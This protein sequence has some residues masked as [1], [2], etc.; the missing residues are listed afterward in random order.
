MTFAHNTF[1]GGILQLLSVCQ[2]GYLCQK[3]RENVLVKIEQLADTSPDKVPT[4][5]RFLLE[6]DF[7]ILVQADLNTQQYWVVAV[8]AA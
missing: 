8:C 1:A 5:S 3:H 7:G 4:E 2:N 6:F